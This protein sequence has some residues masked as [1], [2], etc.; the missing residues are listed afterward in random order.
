MPPSSPKPDRA[1]AG[2]DHPL[3]RLDAKRVLVV[4]A[5][6]HGT[7]AAVAARAQRKGAEVILAARSVRGLDAAE[8]LLSAPAQ[9]VELDMTDADAVQAAV[10][11]LGELDHVAITADPGQPG[12]FL[13]QPLAEA[14]E[15]FGKFWGAFHVA[16]AAAPQLREGGSLVFSSSIAAE[17]PAQHGA[18]LSAVNAA[19]NGLT[20][21]LARE[22]APVRVN[23]VAPSYMASA[24]MPPAALLDAQRWARETLPV[25]QLTWPEE[26][27]A[28]IVFLMTQPTMTGVILPIDGG[29]RVAR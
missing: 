27:A 16:R 12:P 20:I 4:G 11:A 1:P 15:K 21:A 29:L 28:A 7:G 19:I 26:T 6:G 10:S 24:G 5:S 13:E 9:R 18:V 17:A 2:Q 3:D 14:H 23:A 22:L 25:G 8:Q